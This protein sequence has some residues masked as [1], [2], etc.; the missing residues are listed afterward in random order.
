[1]QTAKRGRAEGRRH[2]IGRHVQQGPGQTSRQDGVGRPDEGKL[3]RGRRGHAQRG[4]PPRRRRGDPFYQGSRGRTQVLS[5]KRRQVRHSSGPARA[6]SE[7]AGVRP[8]D[9]V[10]LLLQISR[11][12]SVLRR[13]VVSRPL[14]GRG[15]SSEG[16]HYEVSGQ[17]LPRRQAVRSLGRVPQVQVEVAHPIRWLQAGRLH[18]PPLCKV[19]I[20]GEVRPRGGLPPVHGAVLQHRDGHN[21]RSRRQGEDVR[22]AAKVA[23]GEDVG[24][25][26]LRA[27]LHQ[28]PSDMGGTAGGRRERDSFL[29]LLPR[30]GGDQSSG[31]PFEELVRG[32]GTLRCACAIGYDASL[33]GAPETFIE[34]NARASAT[35]ANGGRRG[36]TV[37]NR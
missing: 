7:G 37:V 29:R 28:R 10:D 33:I 9:R 25:G 24:P 21:R 31:A 15:H 23:R 6:R 36:E 12:G 20:D 2:G 34:L 32:T 30:E 14:F 13:A 5:E 1:M 8:G 18:L 4:R 16:R 17:S 19:R 27:V 26:V 35:H 22:P 3:H 11:V